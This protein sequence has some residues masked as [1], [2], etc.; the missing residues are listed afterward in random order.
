MS[1]G[2][3][4]ERGD[5][6]RDGQTERMETAYVYLIV[7]RESVTFLSDRVGGTWAP[8]TTHSS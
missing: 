2:Q 5:G 6:E 3:A 4:R 1:K 7:A 8:I